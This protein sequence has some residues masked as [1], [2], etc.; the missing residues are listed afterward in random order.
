MLQEHVNGGRNEAIARCLVIRFAVDDFRT[1]YS[2]LRYLTRLPVDILKL[3]RSFVAELN[4]AAKGS[5]VAEAVI[6]LAQAMDLDTVAE[7]IEIAAQ[8][9]ESPCW[10]TGPGRDTTTPAP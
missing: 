7:G 3:D 10:A 4:G 6:R 1:G 5:A 9:T 8:A 2:S